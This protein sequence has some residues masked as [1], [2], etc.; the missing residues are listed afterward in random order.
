MSQI[1]WSCRIADVDGRTL[2][3]V[4]GQRAGLAI[5][6]VLNVI[7]LGAEIKSPSTG[8]VIGRKESRIGSA[9]VVKYFAEDAAEA[10]MIEGESPVKGDMCRMP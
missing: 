10:M 5:G 8:M 1:A 4:A 2:F 7:R 9:K 6:T 3:L